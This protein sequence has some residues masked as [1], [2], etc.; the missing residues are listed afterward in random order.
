MD[1]QAKK[2]EPGL[3]PAHAD[4]DA[5]DMK[6]DLL[7]AVCLIEAILFTYLSKGRPASRFRAATLARL[8]SGA[9]IGGGGAAFGLLHLL[10]N[11]A[12]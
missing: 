4:A 10:T 11:T 7:V 3:Q 9:L 1:Y 12:H 6:Y 5:R 8:R 2:A